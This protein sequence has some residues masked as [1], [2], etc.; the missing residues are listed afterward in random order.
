M[1]LYI[2][3][4]MDIKSLDRMSGNG[5]HRGCM[6]I[7]CGV[8]TDRNK[9]KYSRPDTNLTANTFFLLGCLPLHQLAVL[10]NLDVATVQ[11]HPKQQS[12]C[13]NSLNYWH[14]NDTQSST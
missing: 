4:I 2:H 7:E 6:V 10:F 14:L 1:E 13:L 5:M 8:E 3:M 12:R 9:I 11:Y